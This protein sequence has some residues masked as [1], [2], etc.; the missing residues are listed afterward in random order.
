VKARCWAACCAVALLAGCAQDE[1]AKFSSPT[2]AL[3]DPVDDVYLVANARPDGGAGY[4]VSVSPED[5]TCRMWVDGAAAGVDLRQPRGMALQGDVLWVADGGELRRF[6]RR[7]RAALPSVAVEGAEHLWDVAAGPDGSV[8]ACDAGL[9]AQRRATGTDAIFRVGADGAV[10]VLAR[11]P[12]L[13]QPTGLTA[14]AAGLYV[15]GWR[16][17]SFYEIDYRGAQTDL[18]R[19]PEAGL[20]GLVRVEPAAEAGAASRPAYYASSRAGAAVYRFGLMGGGAALPTRVEEPGRLGYDARRRR[21]LVPLTAA[22]R[23]HV[24]PL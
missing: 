16:D 21:L 23:L 22:E 20:C 14:R 8:Y 7:T 15:V 1:P 11:G 2:A 5:G 12:A 18:A 6:D 4:I 3:H 10:T 9:D 17:G 19:A 13:G 24:E